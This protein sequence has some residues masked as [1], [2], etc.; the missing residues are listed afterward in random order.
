MRQK[1][2]AERGY[3]HRWRQARR[4]FLTANP[5]CVMCAKEGRTTPAT[6][7][8]HIIPHRGDPVLFWDRD[9][10]QALC[11]RHHSGTKQRLEKSGAS[12]AQ[13]DVNGR[14]IW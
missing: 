13:F 2:S 9:N 5:L 14:V 10:W 4:A 12:E 3:G 11:A 6:V 1:S 8:D 7:V